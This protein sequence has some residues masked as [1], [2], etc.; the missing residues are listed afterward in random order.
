MSNAGT[1]TEEQLKECSVI[2][3]EGLEGYFTMSSGA[4][5]IALVKA[6]RL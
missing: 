1:M 5:A 6:H 4:R 2:T 3:S